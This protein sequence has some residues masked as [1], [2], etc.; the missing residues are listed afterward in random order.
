M[1]ATQE[2]VIELADVSLATAPEGAPLVAG[3]DWRVARG[4]FWVVGGLHGAGKS[5]LLA[6]AAGWQRPLGGIC[7]VLGR[8]PESLSE[9]ERVAQ[10]RR[11]GMVFE[12]GAR[13]FHQLSVLENV[14][15]PLRYHRDWTA[16]QA[17]EP[18]R[19][20][21]QRMGL[22]DF[23]SRPA[24]RL[25][26]AWQQRL[27]LA[28]ALAL[29][30]EVLLLDNPLAGLDPRQQEWW[31]AF[32]KELSPRLTLV[33]TSDHLEPWQGVGRQFARLTEGR[34]DL[35]ETNATPGLRPG[36]WRGE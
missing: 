16:K 2:I 15:L 20:A 30:P 24:G 18:A 21:L 13:P 7:R 22:D 26:R 11:V 36:P 5:A 8:E 3:V 33:V 10:R 23:A 17:E 28:R 12:N 29:E 19:T 14:A 32:L 1:D 9:E 6:V 35:P 4:D 25:S 34:W 31:L 27:G